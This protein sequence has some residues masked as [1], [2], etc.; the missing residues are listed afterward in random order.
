M[1]HN[2]AAYRFGWETY[3][4]QEISEIQKTS[5]EERTRSIS[6]LR[7]RCVASSHTLPRE[8]VEAFLG[9][10]EGMTER[11]LALRAALQ[12]QFDELSADIL[13]SHFT[14]FYQKGRIITKLVETKAGGAHTEE[15]N[16]NKKANKL[17]VDEL[18]KSLLRKGFN[19]QVPPAPQLKV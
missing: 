18:G 1:I 15:L 11:E 14:H 12:T 16:C 7:D 17:I 8:D 10:P 9:Y 4:N 5:L 6:E 2:A 19:P 3:A 13:Q